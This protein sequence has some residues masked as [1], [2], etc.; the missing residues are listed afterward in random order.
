MHINLILTDSLNIA[1]ENNYNK[2]TFKIGV[3]V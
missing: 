3:H 2:S 1:L